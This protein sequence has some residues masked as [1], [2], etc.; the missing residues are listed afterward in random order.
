MQKATTNSDNKIIIIGGDH[1]NGLGLARIFGLNGRKVFAVII[2]NQRKSWMVKSKFVEGYAI[3]RT[4]KEGF[5]FI[6]RNFSNE[7]KKPFIFPYSDGAAL[8]LDLRLNEFKDCFYIPSIAGE[9]GRIAAMMDKKAQYD[10]A[11][12][13]SIKMAKSASVS[14]KSNN[15]SAILSNFEYPII[16]KPEISAKGD[17][18][19]IAICA[20]VEESM[21]AFAVL[22]EKGYDFIFIQE[23]IKVDKEILIVGFIEKDILFNAFRVVRK[24]P[25]RYGVGCFSSM[26][27][28]ENVIKKC[29]ELLLAIAEY[30]Y[31]GLIDVECFWVNDELYL[32]EINWRNS[33]G[34]FRAVADG[35]YYAYWFYRSIC[36]ANFK[37]PSWQKKNNSYSMV[38]NADF[39]HVFK[40][41]DVSLKEWIKD[42]R[43][44]KNFA[45]F[46]CDDIKP[47]LY[48][49]IFSRLSPSY[50]ISYVKRNI[51]KR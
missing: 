39:Y 24:W 46:R 44:T 38:E 23:Y 35:F 47:F 51:L 48:K 41:K 18:Q 29:Q 28:E 27:Y 37:V 30:G 36:S 6:K 42:V 33:G 31:K 4:E 11:Q 9:Q 32:N 20:N 2:T 10:W 3:F 13:R 1:H 5:D 7:Q 12:E 49:N 19:D 50:I 17:K 40:V 16:L 14:L 8:E 22:K 25:L 45:T 21:T 43:R 26:I 34:D 15:S